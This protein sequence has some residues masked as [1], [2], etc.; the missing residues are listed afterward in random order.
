MK[1]DVTSGGAM[2][3]ATDCAVTF[4]GHVRTKTSLSS[5]RLMRK[6]L[7][8]IPASL[9]L[10]RRPKSCSDRRNHARIC[11]SGEDRPARKDVAPGGA[12]RLATTA[13]TFA[14]HAMKRIVVN[15]PR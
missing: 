5:A 2:R 12:M 1:E 10:G 6:C 14:G 3:L 4:A 9:L 11:V 8:K 15:K 13:F 7:R